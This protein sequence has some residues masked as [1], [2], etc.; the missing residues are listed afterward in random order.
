VLLN[1][2]AIE[3]A[4]LRK[5]AKTLWEK[6]YWDDSTSAGKVIIP[7]PENIHAN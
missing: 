6:L 1:E 2:S 4:A 3:Q 7:F 5:T